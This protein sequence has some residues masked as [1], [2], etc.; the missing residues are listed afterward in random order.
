MKILPLSDIHGNFDILEYVLNEIPKDSYDVV[1][2]SG[3]VWEGTSPTPKI[4]WAKFQKNIDKPIVMIQ[5]NHDFWASSTFDDIPDIHLLHNEVIEIDGVKF[6]GTPHT[7]NFGNWN[8]MN[9]EDNLFEMWDNIVPKNIDVMLSHGPP[10]GHCDNC[11]QPVYGNTAD[12]KLGSK[13]LL[14][15]LLDK[16]PK[17]VFCGHIHTGNRTSVLEN[18]TKIYNVSCLDEAYHFDVFNPLPEVVEIEL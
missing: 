2:V 17:Y 12:S 10:F 14:A 1:T 7:V 15:I 3:D 6:F 11:N 9:S 16:S 5:G 4:K 13:S 18:G 8:W